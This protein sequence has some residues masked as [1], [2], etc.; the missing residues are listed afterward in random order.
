MSD[1]FK[2]EEREFDFPFYN[3]IPSLS[4]VDWFIF[5]LAPILMIVFSSTNTR[6][7]P[8]INLIPTDF[9][10]LVYFLVT[11]IPVAYVCKG[12]LGLFFKKLKI[13]DFKIIIICFFAYFIYSAIIVSILS[14]CGVNASPNPITEETIT[15]TGFIFLLIQL[16]GEEFFKVSL[17][18]LGMALFYHFTKDRKK[19]L[20]FGAIVSMTIFGLVH[21]G[22]YGNV[23]HCLLVIGVGSLIHIYPYIKTKNILATYILHILIDLVAIVIPSIALLGFIAI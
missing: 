9:Y 10:P 7:I 3:G 5:L 12:K 21:Y 2:F 23:I 1:F 20:I 19:S 11:F 13:N 16:L 17:F 18:I 14:I 4:K 6:A 22:A 8:L 15:L